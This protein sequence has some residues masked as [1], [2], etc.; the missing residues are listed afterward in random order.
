MQRTPGG[1]E[2]PHAIFLAKLVVEH[3]GTAERSPGPRRQF[4]RIGPKEVA[5]ATPHKNSQRPRRVI[6]EGEPQAGRPLDSSGN[7]LQCGDLVRGDRQ[8]LPAIKVTNLAQK[9]MNHDARKDSTGSLMSFVTGRHRRAIGS[10]ARALVEPVVQRAEARCGRR[11][12]GLTHYLLI[13][14]PVDLVVGEMQHSRRQES[15]LHYPS[16]GKLNRLL[17]S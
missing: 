8:L 14:L 1:R 9:L 6:E 2:Q 4:R 17:I 12:P 10:R 3:D 5:G 13:A 16:A 15:F 11:Q 7:A